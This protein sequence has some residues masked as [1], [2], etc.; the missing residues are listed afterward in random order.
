MTHAAD[1]H[2]LICFCFNFVFHFLLIIA[3]T[4]GIIFF[5][6]MLNFSTALSV[7]DQFYDFVLIP[8]C[9]DLI[10]TKRVCSYP[11]QRELYT[12]VLE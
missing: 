4:T 7:G 11:N 12:V 1:K 5:V 2:A 8:G 3:C 9:I 6:N 10:L